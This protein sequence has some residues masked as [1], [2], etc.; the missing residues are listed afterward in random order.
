[1]GLVRIADTPEAFV[2]AAEAAM[3][4]DNAES[5]WLERVDDF[6]SRNSW[7]RT[8]AQMAQLIT[9]VA[10]DAAADEQAA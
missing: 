8:W 2:A 7:D 6:L 4:E 3:R 5:G 9:A 10:D 1:L